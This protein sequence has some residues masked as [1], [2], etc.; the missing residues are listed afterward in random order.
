MQKKLDLTLI[1]LGVSIFV[2]LLILMLVAV[3]IYALWAGPRQFGVEG[4]WPLVFY[5]VVPYL[6]AILVGSGILTVIRVG[7]GLVRRML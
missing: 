2:Y 3:A 1:R 6:G 5:F 7:P 4:S